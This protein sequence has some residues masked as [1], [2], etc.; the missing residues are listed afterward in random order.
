MDL[1]LKK[2][3]ERDEDRRLQAYKDSLGQ[4]TIGVGHLI[5]EDPGR[6][7]SP[8]VWLITNDECDAWYA[9]DVAEA[10]ADAY[11]LFPKPF[12]TEVFG[13]E[14]LSGPRQRAL[15]NMAFN[16]GRDRLAGFKKFITAVNVLDWKTAAAEMMDSKWATQVPAR[17]A[18]LHEMI[19]TG[20]DV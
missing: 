5:G 1:I 14:H 20:K 17:A 13:E 10:Q 19:L 12:N 3:L 9:M 15:I 18:R 7:G 4:W 8:R 6:P 2:Q 16:L 11:A